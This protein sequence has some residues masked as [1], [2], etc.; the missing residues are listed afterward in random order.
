MPLRDTASVSFISQS[1]TWGG[2]TEW[3]IFSFKLRSSSSCRRTSKDCPMLMKV[4]L[5]RTC[6]SSRANSVLPPSILY[7]S[8]ARYVL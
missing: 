8:Y 5:I 2:I 6:G 1:A 7:P 4:P 3:I